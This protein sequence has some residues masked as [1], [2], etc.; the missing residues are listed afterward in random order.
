MYACLAVTWHLHFWQNDRDFLRATAVTRGWNGY[1]NKSQHR[2]ST[3]EKKILPPFEQGFEPA[4]FQSRVRRSNHWAIPAPPSLWM[5]SCA[6]LYLIW[7]A[8]SPQK[9]VFTNTS[10]A[11]VQSKSS[12]KPCFIPCAYSSGSCQ[13]SCFVCPLLSLSSLFETRVR[14]RLLYIVL[15]LE[16]Y[17]L[18]PTVLGI[19]KEHTETCLLRPS[20]KKVC[21]CVCV[22]VSVRV[23]MH[24]VGVGGV[25]C[26]TG[27]KY[28]VVCFLVH[29]CFIWHNCWY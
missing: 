2:K 17:P 22:C 19:Q 14:L 9:C 7:I 20:R 16:M 5:H 29:L 8:L 28:F 12:R 13:W 27:D 23:C 24:V 6:L 3:R 25:S 18:G 10:I 1:R 15:S 21:V 11:T 26:H 4:T